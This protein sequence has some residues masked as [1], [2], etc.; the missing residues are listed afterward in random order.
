MEN[1][2]KRIN[3][4]LVN[5]AK[6]YKKYATQPS[7]DSQKIFSENFVGIHEIK[8]VLTHNKPIYLGF[9]I[10]ENHF[11]LAI[12]EDIIWKLNQKIRS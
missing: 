6:D 4:R 10:L 3:V 7:V 8:S 5:D 11:F 12:A 2:R 1:L 9:S